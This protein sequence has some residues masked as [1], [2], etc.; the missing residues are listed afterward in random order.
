MF[1]GHFKICLHPLPPPPMCK[2]ITRK[3]LVQG[4][5]NIVQRSFPIYRYI[6]PR[7]LRLRLGRRLRWQIT[8]EEE[9]NDDCSNWNSKIRGSGQETKQITNIVVYFS[10]YKFFTYPS[11]FKANDFDAFSAC[12]RSPKYR[13]FLLNWWYDFAVWQL[14]LIQMSSNEKLVISSRFLLSSALHFPWLSRKRRKK[15]LN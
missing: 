5:S 6:R 2:T 11:L 15:N 1:H 13:H 10:S 3:D 12:G 4:E 14:K 8:M 7:H 9:A